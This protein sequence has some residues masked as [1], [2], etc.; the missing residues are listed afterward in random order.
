MVLYTRFTHRVD[1][2]VWCGATV[3]HRVSYKVCFLRF[4]PPKADFSVDASTK[5]SRW[6][7]CGESATLSQRDSCRYGSSGCVEFIVGSFLVLKR[8]GLHLAVGI[9]RR[10]YAFC[11]QLLSWIH[12]AIVHPAVEQALLAGAGRSLPRIRDVAPTDVIVGRDHT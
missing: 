11:C 4:R 5:S 6:M 2:K 8:S 3:K 7:F 10:Y 1:V 12:V 9:G